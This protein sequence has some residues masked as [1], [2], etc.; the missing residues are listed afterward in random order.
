MRLE[1][2][3]DWPNCAEPGCVFK[4]CL[5]LDS[6]KCFQ[7]T[8]GERSAKFAEI[9]RRRVAHASDRRDDRE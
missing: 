5:A 9:D 1:Y 4:A 3:E 2:L 6:H 7:H 8:P